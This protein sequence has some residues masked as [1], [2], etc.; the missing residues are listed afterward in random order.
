M[1]KALGMHAQFVAKEPCIFNE[2]GDPT[3]CMFR[4]M[5][6]RTCFDDP[7][8]ALDI[9]IPIDIKHCFL[10]GIGG[11]NLFDRPSRDIWLDITVEKA[12]IPSGRNSINHFNL[13]EVNRYSPKSNEYIFSGNGDREIRITSN[14]S[15]DIFEHGTKHYQV[16]FN[17]YDEWNGKWSLKP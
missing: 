11:L 13:E 6:D 5:T 12:K 16:T 2:E 10:E 8:T 1:T 4:F 15:L 3:Y 14:H 17:P 9:F 7:Y